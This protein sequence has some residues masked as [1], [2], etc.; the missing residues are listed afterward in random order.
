MRDAQTDP[1]VRRRL[2]MARFA[3]T[4][5]KAEAAR[6]FGCCW[7]TIQAT[8]KRVEQYEH[9]QDIQ[10]LQNKARGQPHRTASD[11]EDR[12]V[13]LYRESFSPERPHH[14][15]YSPAKVARLLQERDQVVMSR[16]T[17]WLILNRRGI[18]DEPVGEQ[19]AIQ[20][21]ERDKPNELWQIDFIENEPTAI[22][23][24]YGIPILDD[25]SRYLVGLHF[26][27]SK[28][29]E[30]ALQTAYQAMTKHGT[31]AE[32]LCDRGGAFV[33]ATGAGRTTFQEMLQTL[34]ITLTIAPRAQTKGKEERINQFIER[35]LLDEVRYD[36]T[37]LA[38]LNARGD[39]WCRAYNATHV[40]ETTRCTPASRYQPGLKVDPVLLK[41]LVAQ[42]ERRKVSREAT[43][44][45]QKHHFAVPEK[46]IGWSVWVA[47]YFDQYVEI[48]AGKTMIGRFDLRTLDGNSPM[49]F[50]L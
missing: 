26:F 3:R 37:S 19:R 5:T 11:I 7:K 8:L 40:N 30:T 25:H 38:D 6:H 31:P 22:G 17:A 2:T 9:S 23:E 35:D 27:L 33:D 49:A 15:R 32:I 47:N 20:R 4:H 10:V 14:R 50:Y 46:Y 34:G 12:V 36:I 29:Q 43:I 41:Q 16:K 1:A 39:A 21:F 44:T 28:G 42:E 13:G 45:Y 24:V 48:T 18:W